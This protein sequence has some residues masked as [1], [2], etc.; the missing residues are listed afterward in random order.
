MVASVLSSFHGITAM[1]RISIYANDVALFIKPTVMDLSFV[2]ETL[3]AFG[4][5]SGLKVNYR[6]SS[7]IVIRGDVD[8]RQRVAALL[9][10]DLAEFP[11]RY[12]GLQLAIKNLT[13][14]EW[15]PMLDKV[16]YFVPAWQRGLIQ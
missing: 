14:A 2:K 12:L 9:K 8:D 7:A 1:Q 11:C 10:C 6:K 16:T 4:E 13:R 3:K 5:A 15:Q